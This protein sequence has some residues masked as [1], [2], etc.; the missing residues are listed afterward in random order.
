MQYSLCKAGFSSNLICWSVRNSTSANDISYCTSLLTV[1]DSLV[2]TFAITSFALFLTPWASFFLWTHGI[3]HL[4]SLTNDILYD[5]FFNIPWNLIG[6]LSSLDL[7]DSV[8]G[9]QV[10]CIEGSAWKAFVS[11]ILRAHEIATDS[12]PSP[13]SFVCA[14]VLTAALSVSRT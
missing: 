11:A 8:C 14:A 7:S 3:R 2:S 13:L 5:F 4:A 1:V 12:L 10:W 6:L 9:R